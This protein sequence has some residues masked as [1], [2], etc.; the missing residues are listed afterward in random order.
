MQNDS[1]S[2]IVLAH[3][4]RP[5]GRKGEVLAELLTD[6]PDRFKTRPQVFLARPDFKGP[7]SEARSV[8]ISSSWLP[9]GRNKGRIVLHFLGIESISAAE[10]IAGLDVI[11]PSEERL[12][13][14][15][16]SVYISD[17]IGCVVYDGG[18]KVGLVGDVQFPT[19][20]DG[21]ARLEDAAPL[22]EVHSAAGDEILVPF[23]KA[24]LTKIDVT[25]KRIDMKLPQGLLAINHAT[26]PPR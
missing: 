19:T 21:S 23:A 5:Q 2:W 11:V 13:L 8:E 4:L 16:E 9:L 22:L 15:S 26:K 14:D 18:V 17:L 20:P 7:P 1:T 3:L 25:E 10:S 24:L 12:P 6:F